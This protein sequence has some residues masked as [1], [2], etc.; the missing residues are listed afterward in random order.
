M[1]ALNSIRLMVQDLCVMRGSRLILRDVGFTVAGGEA[2]T[3]TGA[4]G[5]GKTTL[6]RALS[7]LLPPLSGSITLSGGDEGRSVGEQCHYLG[8][9]NGIKPGLS[10]AENLEFFANFLD[11]ATAMTS[12]A[13]QTLGLSDLEDVP[14]ALL[15]AGQKRRLGLARLLCATRPLWLLDE[16]AVSLDT[17]SQNILAAMVTA[18]L[19]AGG[20]AIAATHM[21]LGWPNAETL[22]LGTLG[23]VVADDAV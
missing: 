12:L 5:V 11:G 18:H 19:G 16:P 2:L 17:A 14:A 7:G 10:V 15:S 22:G 8:H 6:L 9:L 3:L 23:A 20:I 1:I 21:P 13:A 4:N